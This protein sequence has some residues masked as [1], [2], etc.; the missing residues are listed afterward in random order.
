M[1]NLIRLHRGGKADD[2]CHL[3][4]VQTNDLKVH[5]V[6]VSYLSKVDTTH[7]FLPMVRSDWFW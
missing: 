3:V 4:E 1:L 2:H 6:D 7:E 5:Y